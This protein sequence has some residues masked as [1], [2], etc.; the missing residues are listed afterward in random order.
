MDVVTITLLLVM[1][2]IRTTQSELKFGVVTLDNNTTPLNFLGYEGS[3]KMNVSLQLRTFQQ[4]GTVLYHK[5]S[6]E[7]YVR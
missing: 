4:T 2:V 6:S 1:L 3:T 7:G 5:F